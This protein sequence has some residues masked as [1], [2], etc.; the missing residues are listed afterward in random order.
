MN[1]PQFEASWETQKEEKITKNVSWNFDEQKRR[2]FTTHSTRQV[3]AF[4]LHQ[5]KESVR[6]RKSWLTPE[7]EE[8]TSHFSLFSQFSFSLYPSNALLFLHSILPPFACHP[9][10]ATYISTLLSSLSLL[11]G[12]RERRDVPGTVVPE[13]TWTILLLSLWI[14]SLFWKFHSL[15]SLF[16]KYFPVA[17]FRKESK[18]KKMKMKKNVHFNHSCLY[19]YVPSICPIFTEEGRQIKKDSPLLAN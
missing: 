18:R 9:T 6:R 17:H 12:W 4:V 14:P 13:G 1:L 2:E 19:L 7:K 15:S 11:F 5:D 16:F 10:A 3:N 8:T